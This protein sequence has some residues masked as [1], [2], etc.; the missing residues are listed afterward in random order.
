MGRVPRPMS[1]PVRDQCRLCRSI[2]C[3]SR[4]FGQRLGGSS[5]HVDGLRPGGHR[6]SERRWHRKRGPNPSDDVDGQWRAGARHIWSPRRLLG[7]NSRRP[8]SSKAT[9]EDGLALAGWVGGAPPDDAR[10]DSHL[11]GL[12]AK[13]VVLTGRPGSKAFR[14]I[15]TGIEDVAAVR[16]ER[17]LANE[18]NVTV[19]L[20]FVPSTA[21]SIARVAGTAGVV[22]V[23]AQPGITFSAGRTASFARSPAVTDALA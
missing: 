21:R 18:V 14:S 19:A 22:T 10:R 15:A 1:I 13:A 17:R 7:A 12:P 8:V 16:A 23:A 3:W 5:E 9:V 20:A 6:R 2:G 11:A 4:D